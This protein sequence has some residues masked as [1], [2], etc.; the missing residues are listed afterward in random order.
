MSR[1]ALN[2]SNSRQTITPTLPSQ[3]TLSQVQQLQQQA[4]SY[5]LPGTTEK[6]AV[7]GVGAIGGTV[8]MM[9]SMGTMTTPMGTMGMAQTP[10]YAVPYQMIPQGTGTTPNT[11][12]GISA[13]YYYPYAAGMMTAIMPGT[14]GMP[15]GNGMSYPAEGMMY[16]PY[17]Q[18]VSDPLQSLLDPSRPVDDEV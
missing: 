8:G 13:A 10:G 5:S 4:F 1:S 12:A 16:S 17:F 18:Q 15:A 6:G 2:R 14:N 11:A 7:G 9:N 3:I